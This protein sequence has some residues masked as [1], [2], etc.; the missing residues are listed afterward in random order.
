MGSATPGAGDPGHS[1]KADQANHKEQ[2]NQH[3]RS[4]GCSRSSR[5]SLQVSALSSYL[6]SPSWYPLTG[7]K[8]LSPQLAHDH[9]LM[10][11]MAAIEKQTNLFPPQGIFFSSF[12]SCFRL[13]YQIPYTGLCL[14]N[15]IY[16]SEF[17]TLRPPR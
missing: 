6:D 9:K 2:G 4:M 13:Y 7:N 16:F 14:S 17:L 11:L 15:R 10:M 1:K 12:L 3:Q 8:P 5:S